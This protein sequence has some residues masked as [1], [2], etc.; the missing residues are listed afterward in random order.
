MLRMRRWDKYIKSWQL[1]LGIFIVVVILVSEIVGRTNYNPGFNF[2]V[3]SNA[4]TILSSLVLLG[5]AMSAYGKLKSSQFLVNR[6]TEHVIN[7][8]D[9]LQKLQFTVYHIT[10]R[11]V[12]HIIPVSILGMNT[13]EF[14]KQHEY[15][16]QSTPIYVEFEVI[17]FIYKLDD[18]LSVWM[19]KALRKSYD[20]LIG[21][22]PSM[23]ADVKKSKLKQPI[24]LLGTTLQAK[25]VTQEEDAIYY[26]GYP[27]MHSEKYDFTKFVKA[28]SKVYSEL[29]AWLHEHA[30]D[31][32][33]S[34]NLV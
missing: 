26:L 2:G 14:Y 31:A 19:P 11:G 28:Y 10:S 12:E 8:I 20:D 34:I 29:R 4:V 7:A 24:L 30:P 23:P 6:Q 9:K 21:N 18:H 15:L 32:Y 27:S 5:I 22:F 33:D 25:L 13:E 1:W 16:T 3:L 17:D